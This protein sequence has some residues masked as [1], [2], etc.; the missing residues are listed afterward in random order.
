MNRTLVI[1]VSYNGMKWIERCLCS[2][3][4]STEKADIMVIDN[5]STDGTPE[6]IEEN[7]KGKVELR[8]LNTNAGFGAANNV[9]LKAALEARYEYI[10]LLNQ[11]A[12]L[13]RDCLSTLI[14]AFENAKKENRP[15]GIL[16]PIQLRSDRE[17]PE[18]KFLNWYRISDPL[19]DCGI[20][21]TDFIM[22]AH[23][24]I[25]RE[26]LQSVGAFSPSFRH[27]GED[28]NY[29]HRAAYHGFLTGIVPEAYA[30][31]DRQDRACS[32]A[33]NMY[34]KMTAALVK[35]SDPRKN[36]HIRWGGQI[37]KLLFSALRY[38]STDCLKYAIELTRRR[39]ELHANQQNS[40]QTG[41]FL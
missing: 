16:S 11:D 15:Y 13:R 32:K 39:K 25:S 35:M 19:E 31:H 7:F 17:F 41:A 23:W 29:I 12:W 26:C 28:D 5:A 10:Y 40:R 6:W 2:V 18:E 20:K 27:Y 24:M 14:E 9:G 3:A 30:V 33:K 1:I 37:L 22:A 34:L 4:M 8:R 38:T 36:F 21:R